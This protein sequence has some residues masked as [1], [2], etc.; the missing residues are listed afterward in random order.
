MSM[1]C[2]SCKNPNPLKEER[3]VHRFSQ[4]GLDNVVLHGV[5]HFRCPLCGDETFNFGDVEQLHQ[6]I[7]HA[8]I[9]KK[10]P[11]NAREF[12]FLRKL[13]GY[14]A[15]AFAD[16]FE[17]NQ[18]TLGRFERGERPVPTKLDRFLRVAVSL[19]FPPDRNYDLH[20]ALLRGKAFERIELTQ[21]SQTK[22][23]WQLIGKK[24]A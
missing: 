1:R 2:T 9:E 20:D 5:R 23:Q 22:P 18:T 6:V 17:Y 16:L 14:S 21:K 12:K 15:D 3:I 13:L 11:L 19:K 7:G 24:A 8:L 4:C 10:S